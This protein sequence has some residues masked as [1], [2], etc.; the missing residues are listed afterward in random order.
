MDMFC[1][2][3]SVLLHQAPASKVT[4]AE[5]ILTVFICDLAALQRR[6]LARL[7]GLPVNAPH[8]EMTSTTWVVT[9]ANRGIGLEF[10]KQARPASLALGTC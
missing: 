1:C 10:V 8:S 9:G 6:G 4:L 2:A 5:V 3:A 7:A